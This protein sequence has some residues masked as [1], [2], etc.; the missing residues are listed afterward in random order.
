[1]NKFLCIGTLALL[2][3]A[4][5]GTSNGVPDASPSSASTEP[6]E[7]ATTDPSGP[8]ERTA[9]EVNAEVFEDAESPMVLA[10][11]T[12][13]IKSSPTTEMPGRVA[14]TSITAGPT[15]TQLRFVLFA[16]SPEEVGVDSSMFNEFLP[17]TMDI[18]DVAL[19]PADKGVQLLPLIGIAPGTSEQDGSFCICS[20][21]PKTVDGTG[22]TLDA[23]F[24]G[25]RG[26]CMNLASSIYGSPRTGYTSTKEG[27]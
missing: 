17:L 18:R 6:G 5:C 9:E 12:G 24:A 22:V 15:S 23:T 3:L 7:P 20:D 11:S 16:D 25:Y 4:G 2:A 1:M 21:S 26:C 19:E 13:V 8:P 10:E 14:V 27:L